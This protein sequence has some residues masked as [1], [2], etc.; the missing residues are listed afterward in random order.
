MWIEVRPIVYK[1]VWIHGHVS[2]KSDAS[3]MKVTEM[4]LYFS[5]WLLICLCQELLLTAC[6]ISRYKYSVSLGMLRGDRW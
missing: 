3:A 1:A 5:L 4:C 6:N 2:L